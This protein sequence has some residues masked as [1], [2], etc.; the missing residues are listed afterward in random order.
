MEEPKDDKI[1]VG[2]L[3]R[4][5]PQYLAG[6]LSTLLFQTYKNFD[7]LI[8]DSGDSCGDVWVHVERLV[9]ALRGTGHKVDFVHSQT[10]GHSSTVPMNRLLMEAA[11]RDYD[12]LYRLDDDHVVPPKALEILHKNA[13]F[14]EKKH[15]KVAVSGVTPWM[16]R[17]WEGASGPDDPPKTLAHEPLSYF[18]QSEHDAEY[19][20]RIGHFDRYAYSMVVKTDLLS[21]ANF[22][23]RPKIP[24]LWADIGPRC[25]WADAIWF[26][27]L[28]V[29]LGYNFY[30]N[31]GV[32]VWHVAAPSGGVRQGQEDHIK[33]KEVEEKLRAKELHMFLN[34]YWSQIN[35]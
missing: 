13:V 17:V 10:V 21:S 35:G 18:E 9:A 25:L 30:I 34:T 15:D 11:V 8:V 19:F 27:Q 6:L 16:H 26:L 7:A 5:R 23:I 14:L 32:E 12:W 33:G 31:T 2:I 28:K 3:T 20:M 24:I 1:L 22:L 29:F 4:D